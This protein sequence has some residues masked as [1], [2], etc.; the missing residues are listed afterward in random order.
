MAVRNARTRANIAAQATS[1]ISLHASTAPKAAGEKTNKTASSPSVTI[2]QRLPT[3]GSV[4]G[5]IIA[6]T[7]V[8]SASLSSL[9]GLAFDHAGG[10][11]DHNAA[12]GAGTNLIGQ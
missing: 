2:S 9:N 6:R 4:S 12:G 3:M 5:S 1:N 7:M 10:I 8:T 11:V